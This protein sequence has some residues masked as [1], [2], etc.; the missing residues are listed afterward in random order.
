MKAL[1]ELGIETPTEIQEKAIPLLIGKRQDFIGLAQTGTGKTAAFGLPLLDGIDAQQKHTQALIIV[2][3]RELGQQVA[4]Q[5]TD[6]SKYM[7]KIKVLAVYGG[8]SISNQ[9]RA[10]KQGVQIVIATPGRL[11][12]LVD[13]KVIHLDRI[14]YLILDEADEMLN[15]GFKEDI[16]YILSH[17]SGEQATW[18]FSA[19][20]PKEIRK[21]IKEYMDKDAYEVH[22]DANVEVNKDIEHQYTVV[23]ASDKTEALK[24]FIDAN[25]DMK[26]IIF[27]R[28]KISAQSLAEELAKQNYRIDALHGDLNQGQRDK[29]MKRFKA[30]SLN[31]ITATDVAARGIHVND[32]THIIHY[33][34]PDDFDY[35]THRS[36]RTA[37]A[38]KKGIALALL[39]G[40]DTAKLSILE[41]KL[42]IKFNKVP[43]PK[44]EDVGLQIAE[45]WA[46]KLIDMPVDE[47]LDS[48]IKAHVLSALEGISK[49]EIVARLIS[50]ELSKRNYNS[51]PRDLNTHSDPVAANGRASGGRHT[52]RDS[53]MVRFFINIG[54]VDKVKQ[55]DLSE[56]LCTHI[57]IKK[58]ELTNV[59][60]KKN[61]SFFE[62]ENKHAGKVSGSFK[63]LVIEGRKIRV[64]RDE[65]AAGSGSGRRKFEKKRFSKRR[66]G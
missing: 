61:C 23:K 22:I 6:F 21:I 14:N 9:M 52:D 3:T 1:P 58:S 60:L 27:C 10:M 38:G 29:V 44:A 20:M 15:M 25:P 2:P 57:G 24:R 37:R 30:H 17:T 46:S 19:T 40:K 65:P 36:G 18:L 45:S 32:L 4:Q 33:N 47:N 42:K 55:K 7:H 16:D 12:D 11:I 51:Q 62:I 28:T 13:R 43:V 66:S 64:N 56:F 54:S 26:G 63:G 35:Y 48:K 49:E 53:G 5:L 41:R 34:L 8:A 31:L 59:D 50:K 39:S